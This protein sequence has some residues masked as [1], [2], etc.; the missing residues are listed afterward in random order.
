M[1]PVIIIMSTSDDDD[2]ECQR[3]IFGPM[4]CGLM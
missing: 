4:C 3:L 1:S 2:V